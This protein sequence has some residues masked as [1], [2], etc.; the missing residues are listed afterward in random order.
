MTS[1]FH[2]SLP[3]LEIEKTKVFYINI[4]GA[5]SGRERD[6]WI[7]INLFGNQITF[8]KS[9][10]YDFSFKNYKLDGNILPSFHFGVIL[11]NPDWKKL[12]Q[13]LKLVTTFYLDETK[14]FLNK[15]G[16]HNSF[17][18]TDPN[19]FIVEFKRFKEGNSIF[20]N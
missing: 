6:N 14:Y 4:L 5:T 17:F 1:T 18:V 2:L 9:G 8:I 11:S 3:C 10:T 19:G 7:D 15:K 16:E 13:K 20:I 12:Y